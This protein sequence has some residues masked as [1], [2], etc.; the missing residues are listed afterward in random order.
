MDVAKHKRKPLRV[1]DVI[2]DGHGD[3][4]P[5]EPLDPENLRDLRAQL[6]ETDRWLPGPRIP[7]PYV[8][9]KFLTA[10]FDS[11]APKNSSQLSALA[12]TKDFCKEIAAGRAPMLALIGS[13]G[14]GKSHLLYS[15]AKALHG[16][17]NRV[18]TRPWYL[19]ADHLRYGGPSP[20]GSRRMESHE[21]R[22]AI[23]AE[24]IFMIDEVRPTAGTDFDDTELAKIVC[25]AWDNGRAML[26]TTNVSPLAAVLGPAVASRFTQITITGPDHRQS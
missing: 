14:T 2:I 8:A 15:A 24:P 5:V 11:Y 19:L 10:D 12:A 22:D 18:F 1:G 26:I 17:G 3:V 4:T 16:S 23:M 9:D 7:S 21:L 25:R 13:T 6:R 20:F